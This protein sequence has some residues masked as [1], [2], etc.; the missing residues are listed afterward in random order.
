MDRKIRRFGQEIILLKMDI[1]I[2]S[3][4]HVSPQAL[5]TWTSDAHGDSESLSTASCDRTSERRTKYCHQ[6]QTLFS[7]SPSEHRTKL[8]TSYEPSDD[9]LQSSCLNVTTDV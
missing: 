5:K 1:K 9:R 8:W 2:I 6:T 7:L 4:E 3:S